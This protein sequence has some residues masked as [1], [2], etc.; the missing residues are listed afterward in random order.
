ML[1]RLRHR[2]LLQRRRPTSPR[3]PLRPMPALRRRARPR[4][5]TRVALSADRPRTDRAARSGFHC[6]RASCAP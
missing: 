1:R 2:L 6:G 5:P 3:S 4:S